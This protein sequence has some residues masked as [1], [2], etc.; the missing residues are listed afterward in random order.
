MAFIAAGLR[1]SAT[2]RIDREWSVPQHGQGHVQTTGTALHDLEDGVATVHAAPF[3]PQHPGLTRHV[4]FEDR[5]RRLSADLIQADVFGAAKDV[6][7]ARHQRHLV[8]FIAPGLCLAM[9]RVRAGTGFV[10]LEH[11]TIRSEIHSAIGAQGFVDTVGH[12]RCALADNPQ[13]AVEPV[14]A[15]ALGAGHHQVD[16]L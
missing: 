4:C 16:C 15:D 1:V 12:E 6:I 5:A 7:H 3:G 14:V 9:R 10:S 2:G 8:A 11:V 13:D